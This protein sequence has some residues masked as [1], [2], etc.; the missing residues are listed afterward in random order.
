MS[1]PGQ[2]QQ[3]VAILWT[4]LIATLAGGVIAIRWPTI[5]AIFAAVFSGGELGQVFADMTQAQ[6]IWHA[7][8]C[9]VTF[10]I[11]AIVAITMLVLLASVPSHFRDRHEM[12]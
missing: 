9:I 5:Y 10:I 1:Y 2:K 12:E 11:A 7:I 6:M 3:T 4:L 8:I